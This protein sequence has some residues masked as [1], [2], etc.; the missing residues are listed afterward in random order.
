MLGVIKIGHWT[1]DW[2]L[3]W[4][5]LGLRYIKGYRVLMSNMSN[6]FTKSIKN[7]KTKKYT[8]IN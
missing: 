6:K 7:K 1:W 3:N 5:S 2:T 8:Y 4:T